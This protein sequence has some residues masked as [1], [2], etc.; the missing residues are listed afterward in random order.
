M[1][2][3][4]QTIIGALIAANEEL[5]RE[6]VQRL[7]VYPRLISAGKMT[8]QAQLVQM[9]RLDWLLRLTRTLA[10]VLPDENALPF[11]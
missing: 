4:E 3:K 10:A 9:A 8:K 7:R 2:C 5:A 6:R 1:Q 11:D